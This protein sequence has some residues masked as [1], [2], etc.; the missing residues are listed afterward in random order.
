MQIQYMSS[1]MEFKHGRRDQAK[2]S[3]VAVRVMR[4]VR[5]LPVQGVRLQGR[6]KV[7]LAK[8]YGIEAQRWQVEVQA[9]SETQIL[10]QTSYGRWNFRSGCCAHYS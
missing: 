1:H 7:R 2:V 10:N 3:A 4:P 5:V 8:A 6:L 9:V